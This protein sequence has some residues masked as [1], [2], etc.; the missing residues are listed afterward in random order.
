[1]LSEERGEIPPELLPNKGVDDGVDAAV[2]HPQGLCHLHG[3]VQPVR[4]TAVIQA[5]EFLEGAQEKDDVVGSPE[6]K[7]DNHDHEDEPHSLVLLL[8]VATPEQGFYD[9]RIADDHDKQWQHQPQDA[10]H[11]CMEILPS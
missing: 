1:M 4:A 9:S 3:L 10:P 11:N 8:L 6:E 2:R 7:V 5:K